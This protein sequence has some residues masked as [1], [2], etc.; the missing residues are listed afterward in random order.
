MF[1]RILQ[2]E[3]RLFLICCSQP[4]LASICRKVPNM[5]YRTT[6]HHRVHIKYTDNLREL[7]LPES[8]RELFASAVSMFPTL[9]PEKLIKEQKFE[10]KQYFEYL[11]KP[12]YAPL[13]RKEFN[14]RVISF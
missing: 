6:Y 1:Q 2:S 14:T 10:F 4:K 5:G 11:A 3:H 13:Q 8:D 12:K 9:D 7:S